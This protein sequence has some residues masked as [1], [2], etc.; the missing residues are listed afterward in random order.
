MIFACKL[1]R[2]IIIATFSDSMRTFNPDVG[3]L[4][5]NYCYNWHLQSEFCI[6]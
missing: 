6:F 3:I 5:Y 2:Q 4:T 1:Y